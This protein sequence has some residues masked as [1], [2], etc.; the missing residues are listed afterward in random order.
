MS[1]KLLKLNSILYET[2][3]TKRLQKKGDFTIID[4]LSSR[5]V[6]LPIFH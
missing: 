2:F 6:L 3:A 1:V 4:K 5:G